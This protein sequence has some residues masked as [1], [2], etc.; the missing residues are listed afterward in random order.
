MALI[1]SC[2]CFFIMLH[3]LRHFRLV[4]YHFVVFVFLHR[5]MSFMSF[6]SCYITFFILVSFHHLYHFHLMSSCYI[7]YVAF[8]LLHLLGIFVLCRFR[9]V[10]SFY[11]GYQCRKTFVVPSRVPSSG[12]NKMQCYTGCPTCSKISWPPH[13]FN[14]L[15]S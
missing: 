10:T 11:N 12:E 3:L 2:S 9:L 6:S 8:I 5:I 1:L 15:K 13:A 7:F 14:L 4:T